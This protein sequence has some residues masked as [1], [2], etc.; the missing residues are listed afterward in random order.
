M[1]SREVSIMNIQKIEEK[2][3]IDSRRPFKNRLE[4]RNDD[5]QQFLMHVPLANLD[6]QNGVPISTD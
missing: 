6:I 1:N 4:E 3:R 5:I 2:L